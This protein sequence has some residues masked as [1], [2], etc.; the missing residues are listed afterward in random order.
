MEA[1]QSPNFATEPFQLSVRIRHPSIDPADISR[2]FSLEPEHSFRAGSPRSSSSLATS[3]VYPE[4]YWLGVLKPARQLTDVSFPGDARSE[5]AQRQ[6]TALTRSL[7]WALSLSTV[8]F[9]TTHAEFVR[10]LCSEG[11]V[12][13]LL[14]A[15]YPNAVTS[16]SLAPAASLLLGELGIGLEFE[17]VSE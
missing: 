2:A 17:F 12:V 14:A 1:A 13:T 5:M 8:R 3:P 11:G 15:I 9:F 7:T 10:R 16:F 6:L 4:S